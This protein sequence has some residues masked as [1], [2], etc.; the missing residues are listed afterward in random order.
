[1]P[2]HP[3]LTDDSDRYVPRPSKP[4]FLD[5]D[6]LCSGLDDIRAEMSETAAP[7]ANLTLLCESARNLLN[8]KMFSSSFYDAHH[9]ALYVVHLATENWFLRHTNTILKANILNTGYPVTDEFYE[10]LLNSPEELTC[11]YD[12]AN[13]AFPRFLCDLIDR[14]M[15]IGYGYGVAS[16]AEKVVYG[17]FGILMPEHA[18]RIPLE[19]LRS[20]AELSLPLFQAMDQMQ[21][22]T[23]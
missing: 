10:R 23:G 5:L 3:D 20:L 8:A 19:F 4:T 6:E 13:G 14:A 11:S 22:P 12:L 18:S 17:S 1:L 21:P 16:Q 15:R 7:R 2:I 9:R